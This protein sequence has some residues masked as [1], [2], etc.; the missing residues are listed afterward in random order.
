MDLCPKTASELGQPCTDAQAA[1][2]CRSA[3][4]KVRCHG[5]EFGQRLGVVVDTEKDKKAGF[6][7]VQGRLF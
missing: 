5:C 7:P 2:W 1:E 4:D 3:F 6:A